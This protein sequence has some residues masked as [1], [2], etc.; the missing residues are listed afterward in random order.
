MPLS[1]WQAA[2]SMLTPSVLPRATPHSHGAGRQSCCCTRDRR[3]RSNQ[4][5][6]R[7]HRRAC[8]PGKTPEASPA[9]LKKLCHI[10]A[11]G[12][13]CSASGVPGALGGHARTACPP[14]H[15]PAFRGK[16]ARL[17]IKVGARGLSRKPG[18][19]VLLLVVGG[20]STGPSTHL[21]R[22]RYVTHVARRGC[23]ATHDTAP[24]Q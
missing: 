1:P 5:S 13:S 24:Q 12:R 9:R 6:G 22:G 10:D 14:S 4:R 18:Q 11:V 17:S 19:P 2:R 21:P 23:S 20:A 16:Q 8:T 7:C 15:S 3:A